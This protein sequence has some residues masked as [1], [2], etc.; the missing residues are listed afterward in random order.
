MSQ[1][2]YFSVVRKQLN[3]HDGASSQ[4]YI[5]EFPQPAVG[6]LVTRGT[7][8]LLIRQYRPIVD[9]YVWAIPSGGVSLEETPAEAAARELEEETGLRATSLVPWMNCYAS[10]GCSNQRF[11]IFWTSDA[12]ETER[13]FDPAEVIATRWFNRGELQDLVFSNG[14]VDNLSL[15]PLLLFLL[16]LSKSGAGVIGNQ[17]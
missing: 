1:N 9:E 7:D 17:L 12:V 6:V 4:Y 3:S 14:V 13:G 15:S 2:P 16:K 11:E 8:V 10:Y 5:V